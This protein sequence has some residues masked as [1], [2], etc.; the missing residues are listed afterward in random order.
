MF[1][2]CENCPPVQ[3][4]A[5]K[6]GG[7]VTFKTRAMFVPRSCAFKKTLWSILQG[8]L[9]L[10]TNIKYKMNFMKSAATHLEG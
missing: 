4:K 6:K 7:L 3:L 9:S 2:I 8:D 10:K 1:A 5:E